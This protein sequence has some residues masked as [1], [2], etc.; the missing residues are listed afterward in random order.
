M[1][2]SDAKNFSRPPKNY[3]PQQESVDDPNQVG[4]Y[5]PLYNKLSLLVIRVSGDPSE[6]LNYQKQLL[7]LSTSHGEMEPD[8][9]MRVSYKNG[10]YFVLQGK[11]IPI[12]PL[13]IM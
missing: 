3:T 1:V 5:H 7:T 10:Q 6:N 9:N 13:L 2:S 8:D 11:L 12:L 4:V